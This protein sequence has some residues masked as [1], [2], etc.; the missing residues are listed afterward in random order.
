M[1]HDA[2]LQLYRS[3]LQE[4]GHTEDPKQRRVLQS[5]A[6]LRDEL[7][8]H[9]T[10]AWKRLGTRLGLA[11]P[12]NRTRGLYLWGS[13]GR[14]KTWL[15]DLFYESLPFREKRRAHFHR[16]M[17]TVHAGLRRHREMEDPLRAVAADLS[18]EARIICLD[19]LF[20]TDIADAMLLAGLFSHLI[21]R[22]V[23]LV[24]T[25]NVPP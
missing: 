14:G 20:V 12:P 25:S 1:S 4:H 3:A 11:K 9:E 23:A 21:E 19:E 6:R 24:F 5:F 7:V 18:S 8:D 13:V 2:L 17:Q 22:G 10:S 16:F 15:M